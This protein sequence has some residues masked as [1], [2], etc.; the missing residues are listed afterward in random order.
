M[1]TPAQVFANREN[2]TKSTGPKTPDGKARSSKNSL[3]HGFNTKEFIILEGQQEEFETLERRLRKESLPLTHF[4]KETF[5]NLLH[6]AWNLRRVR[7][8]QA[9]LFDGE[10]D[11]LADESLDR[12]VDRYARYEARFERSYYRALGELRRQM[13][14]CVNR[15]T[16]PDVV[17]QTCPDLLDVQKVHNAK[18]S[19]REWPRELF[20]SGPTNPA[21]LEALRMTPE[22]MA[23]LARVT[24]MP[25]IG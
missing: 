17:T 16:I 19:Q 9:E 11:P 15:N 24:P 23:Y 3:K 6:A 18:R 5:N 1:S 21:E 4:N 20:S 7:K 10:T 25:P 2:A 13:T 22:E 14:D 12:K 8:L